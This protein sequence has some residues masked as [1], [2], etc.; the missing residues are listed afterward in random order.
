MK[1]AIDLLW[2]RPG[3]VGGTEVFIRTLLDGF[4]KLFENDQYHNDHI[5]LI[6][7]LDNSNT[8]LHYTSNNISV[9]AAN[10]ASENIT[11]RIIWQNLHLN[12]LLRKHGIYYCFSPVYDRP[13]CNHGIIYINTIHDIQAY[14]YPNYHPLIEVAYSR[15]IWHVD[16][17]RSYRIVASSNFVKKDL[18]NSCH[19]NSK[20][21]NMIY[22]PVEIYDDQF[23]PFDEVKNKFNIKDGEFFY[24][25]GQMIPHKNMSTLIDVMYR[26]VSI[27]APV[28]KL[29]ISGIN[30][31]A[32]KEVKEKIHQ[33]HLEDHVILTG[34]ISVEERN[35]LY[36]HC[37]AFL[38]PS[39]FEG[40]GIPPV[41][42]MLVGTR[43]ITTRCTAIPE[44]TQNCAEYVS[45]PYSIEEWVK[46]ILS[47]RHDKIDKF[48]RNRY[49]PVSISKQYLEY[50]NKCFDDA[51]KVL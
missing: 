27:K 24:T 9:I 18:E 11:R 8:F 25:I 6:T 2:V 5:V 19:F 45:D 4:S 26:L 47:K 30:G 28:Q 20:Q 33:L 1:F 38:F 21:L 46:A 44:I 41:E 7:S 22:L 49:Q 15:L 51:K 12:S 48:D 16:K 42:A 17:K 14:H 35:T 10:I 39:V 37:T 31:N 50:L 3:K 43:V 29:L 36:K 23:S 40:F 32:T 13:V 34:Y